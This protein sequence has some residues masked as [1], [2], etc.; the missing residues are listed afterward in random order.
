MNKPS[1]PDQDF[2]EADIAVGSSTTIYNIYLMFSEDDIE[3]RML[4]L[5]AFS[6]LTVCYGKSTFLRTVSL[7]EGIS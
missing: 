3:V 6:K 5:L 1:I 7:P 4:S 2:W